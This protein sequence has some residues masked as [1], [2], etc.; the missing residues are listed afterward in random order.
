MYSELRGGAR[1]GVNY[2]YSWADGR[3]RFTAE[4]LSA[5]LFM[6]GRSRWGARLSAIRGIRDNSISSFGELGY[7]L[8][9]DWSLSA[10][11]TRQRFTGATYSDVQIAL[12]RALGVSEA[13]L[14]WSKARDRF[15]FEFSSSAY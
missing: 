6:T 5:D 11:T 9:R 7:N 15:L 4:T 14:M 13:R 8:A 2:N 12:V 3:D 10:L 1:A